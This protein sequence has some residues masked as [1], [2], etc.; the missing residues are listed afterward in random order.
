MLWEVEVSEVV[1]RLVLYT[2]EAEIASEAMS[3]AVRGETIGEEMIKD[4]VMD[5]FVE[6]DPI[7]VTEE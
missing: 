3:K 2:V 7:L 1:N 5:R 6:S 4:Y